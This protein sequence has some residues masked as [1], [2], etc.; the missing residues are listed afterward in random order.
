MLHLEVFGGLSLRSDA[1][2]L[3]VAATQRRRLALLAL[4]AAAGEQGLSRDKI[5][6]WLWP[7]SP[8]EKARHAL[9]QL[10]Y[11]SRRD[12][13]QDVLSS[14]SSTLRLN[15]AL[16]TSDLAEFEA[17]LERN[18]AE[19]AAEVYAGPFCDGVYLTG[20]AE[21]GRWVESERAR[22]ARSYEGALMHLA[23]QATARGDNA[24]AVDSWRRLTVAQPLSS[25]HTLGLMHAL[26]AAGDRAGALQHARVYEALVRHD[27]ETAPD[28]EVLA[29]AERLRSQPEG[30]PATVTAPASSVHEAPSNTGRTQEIRPRWASRRAFRRVA[31]LVT[32]LIVVVSGSWALSRSRAESRPAA[33]PSTLAVLPFVDMSA[34]KGD[35]YLG[36]GMTEE[37]IHTLSQVPGLRVVART[38]A[39]SFKGDDVDV[40]EIGAKLNV[41]AVL[42]GSV[43]R[44][45]EKVRVTV[46]LIDTRTGYH[47]WSETYDR[48]TTDVFAVQDEISRSVVRRLRA[49]GERQDATALAL[50]RPSVEAYNLYLQGRYLWNQRTEAS[51]R[52]AIERFR[53][54]IALDSTYAPAHAGLADSYIALVG[55]VTVP[56]EQ[57]ALLAKAEAAARDAVRLAPGM[58]EGHVSLGNLLLYRWDW[59]GAEA[60]FRRAIDAS[61][62]MAGAHERYGILLALVG[63]FDE[64]IRSL[65]LAQELD[66]LSLGIHGSAS[67][68]LNLARRYSE[69]EMQARNLIAMDSAGAS[70]HFRLGSVLLQMGRYAEAAAA[71]ETAIRLSPSSRQRA[72]PMLAYTYAA[73]GE[74][75][76]AARLRPEIERGVRDLTISG[77]F[78][79]AYFGAMRENDRAFEL[80]GDLAAQRQS[81]LQD[82][83]VDPVMD[84]LRSDPRFARLIAQVGLPEAGL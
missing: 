12:L 57:N 34:D 38:S 1:G 40:R 56:A 64:S 84:P 69:A 70:P 33:S 11:A 68:V 23:T 74:Q 4:L 2:P 32:A 60:E 43:R 83:A 31:L 52:E 39:F 42:E 16:I 20:A 77:Y 66:P 51:Q 36:D 18:D 80:L 48:K 63:R 41:G 53:A 28:Q 22:L 5:V 82:V 55:S 14:A 49:G 71:F 72:V 25:R 7:D 45:G 13:G 67:Y 79:A 15:P 29:L 78:A 46:Q 59:A 62:G 27:L 9:D 26:A 61:P 8:A 76:Q 50:S 3:P 21:F 30:R 73:A 19:R 24:R 44:S 37:L 54:S 10:L 6:G 81:C 47:L 35:E 65:R 17:A 75:A 58:A